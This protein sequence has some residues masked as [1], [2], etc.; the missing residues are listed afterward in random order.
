MAFKRSQQAR[1]ELEEKRK[2]QPS[3]FIR[4]SFFSLVPHTMSVLQRRNSEDMMGSHTSPWVGS[5]LPQCHGYP[6]WKLHTQFAFPTSGRELV[7]NLW[8]VFHMIPTSGLVSSSRTQRDR[9]LSS[10]SGGQRKT[11]RC[12]L[13]WVPTTPLEEIP[14]LFLW[15]TV[16]HLMGSPWLC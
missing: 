5:W 10:S 2:K 14:Q 12:P 3:R 4:S 13:L 6:D 11:K 9:V 8:F 16:T 15:R 7:L 1:R